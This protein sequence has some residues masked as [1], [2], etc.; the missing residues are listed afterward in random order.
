[1]VYPDLDTFAQELAAGTVARRIAAI[2]ALLD[3]A[4][5]R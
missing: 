3:A 2:Q 1:M 4:G 5:D